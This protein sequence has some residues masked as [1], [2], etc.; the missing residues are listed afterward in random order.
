MAITRLLQLTQS[1]IVSS[2][3][4]KILACKMIFYALVIKPFALNRLGRIVHDVQYTL[5]AS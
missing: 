3:K 1:Q 5:A 2:T 4:T